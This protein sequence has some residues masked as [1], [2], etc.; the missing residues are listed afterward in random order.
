[1]KRT[2]AIAGIAAFTAG[3]LIG[4]LAYTAIVLPDKG[5]SV[6]VTASRPVWTEVQ[7]PF[8]MDQWGRGKAYQ[9]KAADCGVEVNL[10]FRAKIGFCNCTTGVADDPELERVSDRV[11]IGNDPAAAGPGREIKVAWMKGRSRAYTG[12][13]YFPAGSTALLIA[14]NDRCDVVVATAVVAGKEPTAP[15]PA[16]LEF[17]NSGT[18]MRWAERT[19]GL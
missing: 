16:V 2:T 1:M 19:L 15:E 11:L 8:A 10:Y 3:G 17:L 14:Y 18:V 4:A 6:A 12:V 7:W 9:C 5:R 13:N